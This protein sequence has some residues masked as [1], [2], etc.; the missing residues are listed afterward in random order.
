[1]SLLSYFQAAPWRDLL[2]PAGPLSSEL[3]PSAISE[4]N[5]AVNHATQRA[6]ESKKR[7]AYIKLD[8]KTKIRI[9]KYSS[10][11]GVSVAAK[12]FSMELWRDINLNTVHGY[13]KKHTF[14]N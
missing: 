9:G 7:E 3:S 8:E 11:N 10:E 5:A 12:R 4:A 14:R 6:K 1:M 13:K 2:N